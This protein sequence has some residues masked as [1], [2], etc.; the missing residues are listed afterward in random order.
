MKASNR[1]SGCLLVLAGLY[2]GIAQAVS[3]VDIRLTSAKPVFTDTEP[4]E[5]LIEVTNTSGADAY[6]TRGFFEGDFHLDLALK[7]PDGRDI[8]PLSTVGSPE[9]LGPLSLLD[10]E[11]IPRPAIPCE[12]IPPYDPATG[13][14]RTFRL[15]DLKV[16]YP[17]TLTGAYS[18]VVK[19]PVEVFSE[20]VELGDSGEVFCFLDDPAR[21]AFNPLLLRARDPV[22]C[23]I[24]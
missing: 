7:G 10:A 22:R 14:G 13:D 19:T 3:P 16:Y 21:E 9:P 1:V 8:R 20:F 23:V 6:V 18:A 4:V 17:I 5:V 2:A 15:V 24:E 12:R 11:G